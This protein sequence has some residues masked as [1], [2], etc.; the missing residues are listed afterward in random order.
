MVINMILSFWKKAFMLILVL[1][2]TLPT[3]FAPKYTIA[4][5]VDAFDEET[6]VKIKTSLGVP[7]DEDVQVTQGKQQYWE[8]AN[9][10]L[11]YVTFSNG[12][13]SA[14]AECDLKTGEPVR[15][16]ASWAKEPTVE[17]SNIYTTAG[18]YKY[19]KSVTGSKKKSVTKITIKKSKL[20]ITGPVYNP[21]HSKMKGSKHTFKLASKCEYM[22]T[23]GRGSKKLSKKKFYKEPIIYKFTSLSIHTT[24]AG[25]IKRIYLDYT[26]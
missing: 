22:M 23:D 12:E 7:L 1:S 16:I 6:I 15:S 24:K 19:I 25:K 14:C 10:W 3:A 26:L 4:N 17:E 18:G 13:Y 2:V 11:V 21:K 5:A 9:I 20:T 8:G